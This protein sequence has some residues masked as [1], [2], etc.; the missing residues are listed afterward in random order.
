[1]H[2]DGAGIRACENFGWDEMD[3]LCEKGYIS[4]PKTRA[5]SV[6]V[7]PEGEERSKEYFFKLFGAHK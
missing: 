6:A 4:D 1:M 5:K 7:T 2:N 3:R